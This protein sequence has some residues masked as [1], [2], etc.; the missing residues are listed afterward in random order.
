M[1]LQELLDKFSKA[2][3]F[4][5]S[6]DCLFSGWEFV[7]SNEQSGGVSLDQVYVMVEC[8]VRAS[9]Q[10]V[11]SGDW[12]NQDQ[13]V[14]TRLET[15]LRRCVELGV[16]KKDSVE[17]LMSLVQQPWDSPRMKNL[18]T[19]K[20]ELQQDV[21]SLVSGEGVD[22]VLLRTELLMEAGLD[23]LAYKLVS[24][25]VTS[26]LTDHIVLGSY[27]ITSQPGTL[28]ALVDI[29]IAL[30]A[31]THHQAKL[32]KVLRLLGLEE[33]NLV[34][35]PRFRS[36]ISPP[37]SPPEDPRLVV[38][39]GRCGRLFTTPVCSKVVQIISQW[40]MAGASVTECPSHLQP[41]IIERWLV[42]KSESG[43]DLES[44]L[45]D[46]NTLVSSATQNSF[47][48]NLAIVLWRKVGFPRYFLI[49][50]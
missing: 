33:V 14:K 21:L 7:S 13:A 16:G 9:R 26:I 19:G 2:V 35:L 20:S 5:D 37:S 28:P 4:H 15:L 11:L 30:T 43:K 29:F 38:R 22:T 24:N 25:V 17:G 36:Y 39:P 27:V 3:S 40:S 41:D 46:I 18:L 32:Y 44:L 8:L 12:T 47:L 42:L 10:I 34:H 1:I 50:F 6:L 48:Y 31:A 45:P 49:E 23:K